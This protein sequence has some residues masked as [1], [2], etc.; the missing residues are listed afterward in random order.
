MRSE[1]FWKPENFEG[2][3]AIAP[4]TITMQDEIFAAEQSALVT[5]KLH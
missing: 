3:G 2:R 1:E 5:A 4:L